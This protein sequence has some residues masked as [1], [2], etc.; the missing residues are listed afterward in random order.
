MCSNKKGIFQMDGVAGAD[1]H[2]STKRKHLVK[3]THIRT[4]IAD[5]KQD[6]Y[7]IAL[8]VGK[9]V[10]SYSKFPELRKVDIEYVKNWIAIM[11]EHKKEYK[12]EE[13]FHMV[14]PA[15][16]NLKKLLKEV[17]VKMETVKD[18]KELNGALTWDP[19]YPVSNATVM[20]L[21]KVAI[22]EIDNAWLTVELWAI[23]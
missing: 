6:I 4:M 13:A 15:Y 8:I 1:V 3:A 14:W 17:I 19:W 5:H 11:K 9:R 23:H 16:K 22:K 21:I 20:G 2:Y 10:E 18:P 7:N 12:G